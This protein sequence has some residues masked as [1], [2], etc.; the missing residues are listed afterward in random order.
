MVEIRRTHGWKN[1]GV[2]F[3]QDG[4]YLAASA[5]HYFSGNYEVAGG[6]FAADFQVTRYG[7]ACAIYGSKKKH[8]GHRID[9]K[10]MQL[11]KI[12][13]T[14]CP[15]GS[16]KIGTKIRLTRSGDID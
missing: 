11:G 10:I 14:I 13:G 8:T 1:I 16:K 5:D 3:L 9:A 2:A 6:T 7:K 12:V 15:A 4:R